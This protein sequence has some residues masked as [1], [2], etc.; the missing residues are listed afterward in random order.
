[1]VPTGLEG[2]ALPLTLAPRPF[3]GR[4]VTP[5]L[6]QELGPWGQQTDQQDDSRE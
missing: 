2:E 5:Q 6:S 4:L 1:M 3:L